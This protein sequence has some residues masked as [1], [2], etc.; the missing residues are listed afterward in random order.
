MK[1]IIY[2]LLL[3]AGSLFFFSC[4]M[5]Q[6]RKE[7]APG[8]FT[9][10][11]GEIKLVVLDPGHFHASLLQKFPQ[12]QVNDTVFV[13]APEGVNSSVLASIAGLTVDENLQPGSELSIQAG[14]SRKL[15]KEGRQCCPSLPEISEKTD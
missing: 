6:D 12:K 7:P 15:I 4:K 3:L 13:Y 8:I 14:L 11:E 2:C 10:K 9:G 5:Q 1:R